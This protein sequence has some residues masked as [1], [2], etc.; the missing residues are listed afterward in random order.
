MNG[1][2]NRRRI[3]LLLALPVL[4][5]LLAVPAGSIY[6]AAAGGKA[7]IR[8]HEIQPAYDQLDESTHRYVQC[9]ECH[10][11]IFS[12][13]PDFI[14][15]MPDSSGSTS[16]DRFPSGSCSGNSDISRGMNA[17]CGK[18]HQQEYAAW[19]AGPHHVTY[20]PDLSRPRPQHK[21]DF[22]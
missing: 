9:K 16:A 7:C 14:S 17:R 11:S 12:T 18:C 13:D 3:W 2:R 10:G 4:I 15:T 1:G 5:I 20:E 8:C 6:Y 21:A 22:E 19:T